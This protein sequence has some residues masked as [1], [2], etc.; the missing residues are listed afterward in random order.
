VMWVGRSSLF[1]TDEQA[2]IADVYS[3]IV[4]YQAEERVEQDAARHL[5]I[6]GT[7]PPQSLSP[8]CIPTNVSRADAL[9]RR[10]SAYGEP[11]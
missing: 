10:G 3:L 5:G 11:L 9:K 8:L 4:D 6:R 2:A 1:Q 7:P